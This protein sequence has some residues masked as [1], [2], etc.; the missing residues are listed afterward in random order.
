MTRPGPP[1]ELWLAPRRP[2]SLRR[3][4][5]L[6]VGAALAVLSCCT[7]CTGAGSSCS[8]DEGCPP[9]LR[10]TDQHRCE[11]PAPAPDMSEPP[12]PA[13]TPKEERHAA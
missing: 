2:L 11:P 7:S 13:M 6:L 5:R 9:H 1:G 4:A 12:E 8:T 10:C 3:A